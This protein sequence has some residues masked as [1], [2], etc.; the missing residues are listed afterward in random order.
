MC[1]SKN[2][3]ALSL[4]K[5]NQQI[6][7]SDDSTNYPDKSDNDELKYDNLTHIDQILLRPG[8][9]VGSVYRTKSSG[10]I[11][12]L[13]PNN[14]HF[15]SREIYY[16]DGLLRLFIEAAC[17]AIDNIWRSIQFKIPCKTIKFYI[18][19]NTGKF[20]VI[21]DGMPIPINKW[22]NPKTNQI[23]DKYVPEIIF[24]TLISSSNYRDNEERKTS[25]LNGYGIKLTSIFSTQFH[26]E[27]FNP[28]YNAIYSQ[29]WTNNMNNCT[30]AVFE[31]D[32]S[33]FPPTNGKSGLTSVSWIPDYSRFQMPNGLDD[34]FM[35]IIEKVMYDYAMIAGQH[36][37]KTF[38]N[39]KEI[40][41]T[42][43]KSYVELYYN[44]APSDI[45]Q[46]QS[47]DCTIVI[48]PKADETRKNELMHI[49]F[50]NGI[51]TTD[52]GVHIDAWEKA[53]FR[54]II[55]KINGTRADNAK[56]KNMK[57]NMKKSKSTK[58]KR[59]T[60]DISHIRKY[61][62][63][64]I[65]AEVSNPSFEGQN[66][67]KYLSPAIDTR[68]RPSDIAKIMKWSFVNEIEELIRQ[69]ELAA[70]KDIGK[71]QRA[72]VY[73]EGLDD[74]NN[75]HDPKLR[76]EC[77]LCVTEGDS[78]SSYVA[79]GIQYGLLGKEGRDFI[80]IFPIRGKFLNVRKSSA[81]QIL[82]NAEVCNIIKALGLEYGT[83][84]SISSNR[85]KLRYGK[86]CVVADADDDGKHIIGLLY[87][88]FDTLFPSLLKLNDYFYFLRIPI[89]KVNYKGKRLS[90][91]FQNQAREFL[92]SHVIPDPKKAIRYFKGLGTSS[93]AD[94]KE[95]FGKYAVSL[96][97][98]EIGE[99][100]IQSIF[101]KDS[102][103]RKSWLLEWKE[104]NYENRNI[105]EYEVE[106]QPISEFLDTEVRLFS[107]KNCQRGIPC[108]LDG[109]KESQRKILSAAFKRKLFYNKHV[110]KV[111]QFAGYVA[112]H[113]EYHYGEQ[114]L[115]DTIIGMA[116]NFAGSNNIP[117][118]YADGNFGSRRGGKLNFSP[119]DDASQPRYIFTK[120][121][122]LTRFIYRSEDDP[123]LPDRIEEGM[124]IEKQYY[125]PIIPIILVNGCYGIGTGSSSFIPM[126][127]VLEL[128]SWIEIWL[129]E[130]GKINQKLNS[131]TFYD[132]PLL[133]PFFRNFKGR[134]ELNG[135]QIK[136]FG[137]M[138]EIKKNHY[139]VTEL[140]IGRNSMSTRKFANHLAK[141]RKDKKIKQFLDK[142]KDND[143]PIFIIITDD[144]DSVPSF[145]DLKLIDS[146]ST[147]N[148]VLF[149]ENSR[150]HKFNNVEEILEYYCNKRYELYNV[151]KVGELNNLNNDLKWVCNKIKFI[152]MID[153][154][155]LII[156]NRP[157]DDIESEL[158]DLKF[159]RK[160]RMRRKKYINKDD[161]DD[162]N[163]NDNNI[164]DDSDNEEEDNSSN[165]NAGNTNGTFDY[166]LDIKA[167][168]L[169]I[170]STMY[171]KLLQEE[172]T[173]RDKIK[174]LEGK[175][176]E[177][178]WKEELDEFKINYN[179]WLKIVGSE[180][181]PSR[182]KKIKD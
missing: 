133:C 75:V 106:L 120:L 9:Y 175:T 1:P 142:T 121:D 134:V 54:P 139:C 82:K 36:G 91:I 69:K 45:L 145:K 23:T 124:I 57:N 34:E 21:N 81:A 29:T 93:K 151:R 52:G 79:N 60:I 164:N 88:F 16:T 4:S 115:P 27:L 122:M 47:K 83:D 161:K 138:E 94:I 172:R 95:D 72:Y 101:N 178:M 155:E 149:D 20:T 39:D 48:A 125:L 116:Q 74:A 12:V 137:V 76:N 80:G 53:V 66:K 118:F 51:L 171:K 2:N 10:K 58:A 177:I 71:K 17:N 182:R 117:L 33:L 7:F 64:F 59:P 131:I 160:Q 180:N 173:L 126:Y 37:V 68:V 78:A 11:W 140:P 150:L 176:A 170:Q 109:L 174:V 135:S 22:T 19:R 143:Y 129:S 148:M 38:Y 70:I 165:K 132:T 181:K 157:E 40:S 55:N 168:S 98:D 73:V 14:N 13:D 32:Q 67:T 169:N 179:K 50:I 153:K 119:G 5:K 8:M 56:K 92:T 156:L 108:I 111:A 114:N 85:Q 130:K 63:F 136:T 159:D 162:N 35:S 112:E 87:N 141:L 123:Y 104:T 163:N 152:T 15:I 110:I 43:L 89:V 77:I 105:K 96:V 26:I 144:D 154:S 3:Q 127:N 167:R 46:L 97:K 166:L 146:M 31:Y 61:F 24:G 28:K 128:I 147:T 86:F 30:P 107:I 6:V 100:L 25:G 113:M 158:D 90:F 49:S 84:Y 102:D 18:D 41:I 44:E 99:K 42:N 62:S 103:F 65:V